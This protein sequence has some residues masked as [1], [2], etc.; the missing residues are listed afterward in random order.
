MLTVAADR[1]LVERQLAGACH[2][3]HCWL[4]KLDAGTRVLSLHRLQR[5]HELSKADAGRLPEADDEGSRG[6]IGGARHA[7]ERR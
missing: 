5:R 7:G 1:D 2:C 6:R 4:S 3:R